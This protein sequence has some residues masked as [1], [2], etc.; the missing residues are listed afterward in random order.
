MRADIL[1][2]AREGWRPIDAFDVPG[3][4]QNTADASDSGSESETSSTS[5][6]DSR[7]DGISQLDFIPSL[8][9]SDYV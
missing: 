5:L 3:D 6:R 7:E 4:A 8:T 2:K 1:G 9:C